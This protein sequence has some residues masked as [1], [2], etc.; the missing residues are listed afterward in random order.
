MTYPGE[1]MRSKARKFGVEVA[2]VD[3]KAIENLCLRVR[4]ELEE[5]GRYATVCT[6]HE[7]ATKFSSKSIAES[8]M[9]DP[10]TFCSK[11]MEV[12]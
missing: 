9:G 4:Y 7:T 10:S 5:Q 8:V 6:A 1:I 3:T 11:C 12:V 2:L